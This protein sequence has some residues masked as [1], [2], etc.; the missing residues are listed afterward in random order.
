LYPLLEAWLE[1]LGVAP[2]RTGRAALAYLLTALLVAQSLQPTRLLRALLSPLA[3]PARQR[4]T[5]LQRLLASPWLTPAW[6]TPHLV[7]GA[8]ALQPG[9]TPTLALDS[10]RTGRWDSFTVGLCGHARA[11]LLAWLVLP[12]P[13]P[14]GA[15]PR[16][17]RALLAQVAACWPRWAPRPHLVA[18]RLFASYALLQQLRQL[19]WG[20][21]LRLRAN[22]TVTVNGAVLRVR[23]LLAQLPADGWTLLEGAYGQGPRAVPGRLVIGRGLPLLAWH[24]RDAGSARARQRRAKQRAHDAGYGR[25]DRPTAA[26]ETDGWVVLF[27]TETTVL[28]AVRRYGQRYGTE[29]TY[30]DLQSGWD[31]RHGWDLEPVA[32]RQATAER[33]AALLSLCALGQLVQHWVGSQVAHPQSTGHARWLAHAWT[34]HGRLSVWARGRLV[35]ELRDHQLADWLAATLQQGMAALRTAPGGWRVPRPRRP[36]ILPAARALPQAA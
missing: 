28:G 22:Q 13:W 17:V 11:Q 14:K 6:L 10:V 8:L 31:G 12:F 26:A 29:G 18:D 3:V 25:K 24:Q 9:E 30:R 16:T 34:V 21:T 5:R 33:V 36:A 32:A 7:R 15:V 4:Y 35:F 1:A 19:R 2:H 27:T 20:Y 23:T